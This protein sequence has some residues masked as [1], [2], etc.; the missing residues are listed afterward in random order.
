MFKKPELIPSSILERRIYLWQ[1][2]HFGAPLLV[3]P[4]ASGM[5]H[6]WEQHG[7]IDALAGL[8]DAGRLKVYCVESNVAE[9]WTRRENDPRWRMQRHMLYEQF[10]MRELVPYIRTDCRSESIPLA[11]TGCSLGGYYAANFALKYPSVFRYAL[12]LSARYD[13]SE[14]TAGLEGDDAYFNN[15]MAYVPNLH[16]EMLD[17]VRSSTHL[18]LVC[19][20]GKWEDGNHQETRRF[21][22]VLAR[23]QIPHECDI[24][25]HDVAHE[26]DWWCRQVVH[27]LG[28]EFGG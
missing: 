10:I 20:Q 4:S 28:R 26:W 9:A 1:Y 7:M 2:G 18:T 22:D 12:C 6:E 15:P 21:G 5:A 24:W 14:F 27:H 25:G 19:G 11:V 23:K 8:I 13:V 17:Q 3:F 16:G